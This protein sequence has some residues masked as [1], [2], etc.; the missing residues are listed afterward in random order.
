M[1][2]TRTAVAIVTLILVFFVTTFIVVSHRKLS[3]ASGSSSSRR[4]LRRG[5]KTTPPIGYHHDHALDRLDFNLQA[6]D[7]SKA[8]TRTRRPRRRSSSTAAQTSPIV[9]IT[10]PSTTNTI[11][12]K[13]SKLTYAVPKDRVH[14]ASTRM[15][16]RPPNWNR[17]SNETRMF[18]KPLKKS[19]RVTLLLMFG[20]VTKAL[21]ARNVTFWMDGGTLLGSYRH[22]N[23]IPW[24]D[25]VDLVLSR[26]QKFQARRAIKALAPAYQLYVEKDAA[27]S[28]ELVWRVFASNASVQST[29]KKFRFPTVNLHFYSQNATH[30]WLEPR[31]LRSHLVWR[32][33]TVS[34]LYLRPFDKYWAPAPCDTRVYL[35]TEFDSRVFDT[36]TPAKTFRRENIGQSI[37]Q[38]RTSVPCRSLDRVP[39]VTRKRDS[40]GSITET[41]VLGN[42]ILQKHVLHPKC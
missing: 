7:K 6:S 38:R 2:V 30:I 17:K 27:G 15:Y 22:H 1:A 12:K 10:S 11:T 26:P 20:A 4:T 21:R 34:P 32:K 3:P 8:E 29:R 33:K 16:F 9:A 37:G 25:N 23:L 39:V 41:L 40:D 5:V 13:K 28:S 42:N 24:D 14:N 36:C 18:K 35:I 19:E 31:N